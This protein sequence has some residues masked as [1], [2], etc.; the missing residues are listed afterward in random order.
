MA[1]HRLTREERIRGIRAAL[2]SPRTP[3]HL[4]RALRRVLAR[5]EGR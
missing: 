5:L 3:R 4:K 1:R 2:R